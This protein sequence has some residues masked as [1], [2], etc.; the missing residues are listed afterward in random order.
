MQQGMEPETKQYLL[1]VLN[2]LFSGLAWMALNVFGGLY[3]GYAIIDKKLSLYNILFFIW[4][5]LSLGFL[6][7]YLYRVWKK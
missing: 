5:L 7:Y 6:L 1:K 3:L 4:F 2:S